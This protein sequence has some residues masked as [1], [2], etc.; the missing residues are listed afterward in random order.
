M[1]LW[2]MFLAIGVFVCALWYLCKKLIL[3]KGCSCGNSKNCPVSYQSPTS[4]SGDEKNCSENCK[5]LK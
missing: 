5:Y 1:H 2:E 3:T 4:I